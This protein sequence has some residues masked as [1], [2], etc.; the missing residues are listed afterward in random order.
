MQPPTAKFRRETL[1]PFLLAGTITWCSGQPAVIPDVRWL[2]VDKLGHF[3]AYGALAT[4]IIRHPALLRWP[5][6]GLWWALPLAS[7]YGLGDEFRQSLTHG[8]RQ[9]D[10][11]DWVADTVGA[12]VA[13]SLYIRW[14]WYH[15]LLETPLGKKRPKPA[16]I[17]QGILATKGAEVAKTEGT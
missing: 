14:P 3:A 4:A 8:I 15:R 17:Q 10:L 2:E 1:W 13:V 16:P 5:W 11:A 7:G 6:L 12:V 9:Y